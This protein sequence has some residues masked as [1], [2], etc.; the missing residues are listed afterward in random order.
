MSTIAAPVATEAPKPLYSSLFVQVLAAL[1]LGIVLGMARPAFAVSLKIFSDAFLKLITMIVAP[2]VFCVVV[3]GIAGA[4]DLK[5][6]GRVGVK[7][8]IYFETM[9]TVALVVGLL[10]AYLFG[11]GHGMN[12]DTSTLDAKALSNY[13]DNAHKLQGGGIGSFLL[14]II[15]TTS[16][17]ALSR[18]NVLEGL[19]FS[20]LF[21]VS[22]ALVG[23]EKGEKIASLIA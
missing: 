4:G 5:K 20:L 8:L 18:N 9:T 22:L 1:V 10:L 17:D 15:P 14:N 2:I 23:G 19:F 16:F 13:A 12:I 21:G 3:H 6:V 7:A 11:P